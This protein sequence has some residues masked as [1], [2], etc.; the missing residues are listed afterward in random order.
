MIDLTFRAQPLNHPSFPG[1][2]IGDVHDAFDRVCDKTNWKLPIDKALVCS[3]DE[4]IFI[5]YA[6][7][8]MAGGG[9]RAI[10]QFDDT[11]RFRHPGYYVVIGA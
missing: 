1:K 6:I 11:Y 9:A 4:A 8:F 7:E 10:N 3:A 5:R 2:T